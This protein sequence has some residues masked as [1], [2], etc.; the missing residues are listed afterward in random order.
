MRH[1]QFVN[2]CAP[3]PIAEA[4]SWVKDPDSPELLNLCQ[5]VPAH[6]PP[7]SLLD[8]IGAA[9]ARGEGATYTDIAGIAPLRDAL[10]SNINEL[11]R[12]DVA[13]DDIM[14][15]AGCNQAFCAAIDALCQE[16]DEV[17][18]PLPYY[19]NH[20]MW[21]SI[22]GLNVRDIPFDPGS[23]EP[24]VDVAAS[25]ISPRTRA[26]VLVSPNNPTGARYSV[27]CLKN[28]F[29]LAKKNNVALIIDE[30]Y[31]DFIDESITPHTLFQRS[32]W[33]DH[34]VHLYSFSKVFALT[35]HRVGAIATGEKFREQLE[36]VQD[37]V[38][39]NAPHLGQ[40]AA[41]YGL[42]NLDQWKREKAQELIEKAVAIK[43]AFEHSDLKY[44]L[45]S[46]GAYFA[47]VEHPFNDTAHAVAKRLA[48]EFELICLPG[49][50][51]GAGQ[52]NYLRFAFA[53]LS[54]EKFASVVER[55]IKSQ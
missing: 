35:G 8:H 10:A 16:G 11:Y 21:L 50:Y 41:L 45:V 4:W 34:F 7:Q 18:L 3:A 55:L 28:F 30:T 12:G 51:F 27:E 29:A 44:K 33:R 54:K 53:N 25:L 39:I 5:A 1:N 52:E 49:T 40:I 43:T 22:R 48:S 32:D 13:A 15:T 9:V 23:P 2:D 20:A 26:I 6:L 36:K 14:M 46:S 38:A 42:Q 37:C 24:S 17:I 31:R 19:F 47:Y